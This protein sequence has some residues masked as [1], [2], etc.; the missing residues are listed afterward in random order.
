VDNGRKTLARQLARISYTISSRILP[1]HKM[2]SPLQSKPGFSLQFE[3]LPSNLASST[4]KLLVLAYERMSFSSQY[5]TFPCSSVFI[6]PL[7]CVVNCHGAGWCWR[8]RSRITIV[9]RRSGLGAYRELEGTTFQ[10]NN[11]RRD[12]ATQPSRK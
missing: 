8:P 5:Q 1:I 4:I 9:G 11:D 10:V 7:L 3:L 6:S 12:I 2:P